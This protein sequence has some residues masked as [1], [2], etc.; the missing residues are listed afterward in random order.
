[1]KINNIYLKI[2][3][4]P[5]GIL[6]AL[7]LLFLILGFYIGWASY[8]DDT[9]VLQIENNGQAPLSMV[10][11]TMLLHSS[12]FFL[13]TRYKAQRYFLRK[14][15]IISSLVAVCCGIQI[16]KLF[17]FYGI[18]GIVSG[19]FSYFPHYTLLIMLY[20]NITKKIL[21]EYIFSVTDKLKYVIILIIISLV[22]VFVSATIA[23]LLI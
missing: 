2:K 10:I 23:E 14:A 19:F 11:K 13:Y 21:S 22:H 9:L 5:T 18:I 15:E 8:I 3:K 4:E 20:K 7:F 6:S 17:A 16:G 1:M 12:L